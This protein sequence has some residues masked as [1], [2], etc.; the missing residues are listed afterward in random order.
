MS[1]NL[2]LWL[3][4]HSDNRLQL[5]IDIFEFYT[6]ID[7]ECPQNC[8]RIRAFNGIPVVNCADQLL[9]LCRIVCEGRD[10]NRYNSFFIAPGSMPF[11]KLLSRIF[12]IPSSKIIFWDDTKNPNKKTC[13]IIASMFSIAIHLE[14]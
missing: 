10:S 7:T 8:P 11:I 13:R 5:A 12:C 14:L 1:R 2:I 3:P 4:R 9:N 6:N